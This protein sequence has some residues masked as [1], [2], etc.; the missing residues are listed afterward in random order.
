MFDLKTEKWFIRVNSEQ[1]SI[2]VQ[3]WAF[4]QGIG[5]MNKLELRKDFSTWQL[6][7]AIGFGHFGGQSLGQ[8]NVDYWERNGHKE[9][10]AELKLSV[11]DVE[12]PA[13]ESPQQK[14]IRELE[15]TIATAAAQIKKLKE[16]V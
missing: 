2:A 11:V 15:E 3:E 12:L 9:I 7:S 14:Q 16:G 4:Q 8:A 1:E 6:P 5:W 10:K 13:V